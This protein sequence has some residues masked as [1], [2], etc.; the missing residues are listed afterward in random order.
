MVEIFQNPAPQ[1]QME[2]VA[3][4]IQETIE[5]KQSF[6]VI[7]GDTRSTRKNTAL[8]NTPSR[9]APKKNKEF[10][11]F[12]FLSWSRL[13]EQSSSSLDYN[14]LYIIQTK[15]L[16]EH[17]F[18]CIVNDLAIPPR[19]C[20]H[21]NWSASLSFNRNIISNPSSIPMFSWLLLQKS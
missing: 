6:C 2:K 19:N 17:V 13:S 5:A 15:L 3:K 16:Y 10:N 20:C 14:V 12:F 11:F 8:T 1:L 9:F 4:F 21:L 7:D 18:I